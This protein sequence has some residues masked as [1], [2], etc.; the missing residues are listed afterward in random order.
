MANPPGSP[1]FNAAEYN[2]RF[3]FWCYRSF[4]RRDPDPASWD[5]WTNILNSS[6]DYASI[7]YGFVYSAEYRDRLFFP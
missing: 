1:N 5:A 7:V 6:G 2:R 3:I 4:L